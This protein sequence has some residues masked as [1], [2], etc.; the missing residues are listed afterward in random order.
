MATKTKPLTT[1][2]NTPRNIR[3]RRGPAADGH[4]DAGSGTPSRRR[5]D[6]GRTPLKRHGGDVRRRVEP[7][8]T[9]R[10]DIEDRRRS[11]ETSTAL[12]RDGGGQS[13]SDQFIRPRWFG[14]AFI[15][16]L[17]ERTRDTNWTGPRVALRVAVPRSHR[18][19]PG[20]VQ[21]LH[22]A[23]PASARGPARAVPA[24]RKFN[25]SG[26]SINVPYD[27]CLGGGNPIEKTKQSVV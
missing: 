6:D 3:G 25:Y 15:F 8:R 11:E 12:S 20:I 24:L 13:A 2:L 16:F 18:G 26:K 21:D 27:Y 4:S 22:S 19:L 14:K 17:C 1:C 23:R 5:A 7:G 10:P 9:R